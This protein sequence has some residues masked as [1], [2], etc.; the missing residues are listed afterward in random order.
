MNGFKTWPHLAIIGLLFLVLG[1]GAVALWVRHEQTVEA[2]AL[3]NAARIDRVSGEV[4]LNRGLDD[5]ASNTQ[6][7]NAEQNTPIS[8][9]DRIYTKNNSDASVAFTGRNFA[10]LDPNTSLD[11][12]S[13][14]GEK[15]QVALR[16]GSAVFDIGSLPSNDLFEVATPC[17][18]VDLT[19]PGLYQV[20]INDKGSAMAA[21]LSGAAQVVG[22]SGTGRIE[23]GEVL[24][25]PCQ[26]SSGA[27][28][29]RIEP[30]AAGTLVD[31]YYRYRY[32]RT[33]DGRY[34]SYDT[35]LNDP[36]YYDPYRRFNSYQ[37][38]S[39]YIPGVY[40]L[41]DYG[42]WQDVSGYGY[43]WHPRVDYGWAPYQSGYWITDY[44]YGLTWISNEPWGYAP[45]HYGRW[46][47][48]GDSWFWIP[49]RVSTT[50]VYSPALVAFIPFQTETIGW[51]PLA[52][53]DPYTPR[54][55]DP[56]WNARYLTGTQV[57]AWSRYSRQRP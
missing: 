9:G 35:Y 40:D 46:A 29:S 19:G 10:R 12:L 15:T 57:I 31:S 53:E 25:V 34:V 52:P 56:N 17:G 13:L 20:E 54:Y 38:V 36:Y 2:S 28:L 48:V 49:D 47:Y 32:P 44:P 30:R 3:P 7:V 27:V 11:V 51:V 6:W 55:Y 22:Q 37:Y 23:K 1:A 4:G 45:Y 16:D 43:G 33:Y 18:A 8:V 26:G 39:D 21:A 42:D 24:T 50:A 5:N 41:D 14:S